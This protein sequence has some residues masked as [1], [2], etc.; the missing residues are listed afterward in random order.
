[1]ES[2]GLSKKVVRAAVQSGCERWISARKPADGKRRWRKAVIP[3]SIDLGNGP[4]W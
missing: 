3:D 1:M 2:A 4:G